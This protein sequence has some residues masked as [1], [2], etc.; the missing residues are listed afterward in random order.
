MTTTRKEH[1]EDRL[2]GVERWLRSPFRLALLV[3]G[4]VAL[5]TAA[6]SLGEVELRRAWGGGPDESDLVVRQGV[7]WLTWAL[8]AAPLVGLAGVLARHTRP[9]PVTFLSH[10]P[11]AIVVG[12]GILVVENELTVWVQGPERTEHIRE[13]VQWLESSDNTE[14]RPPWERGGSSREE[15]AERMGQDSVS[16]EGSESSEGTESSEG[17]G[18]ASG[19]EPADRERRDRSDWR[20]RRSRANPAAYGFVTGDIAD[21]FGRRWTLRVPRYALTYFALIGIGL[22]IRSFLVGRAREREAHTL[23]VRAGHLESALTEAKLGALQGQ[24]MPHFLFNALHSIGGLIRTERPAEALTALSSIGDLLRTSLDAGGE[25]FV[26]LE[27]E[28][29][30]IERYLA[31]EKLRLGDR[32][33]IEIDAP[34]EL[35]AAEVPA[36]IAQPL[37][38][39][40]IKHAIADR[41]EGGS[42]TVRVRAEDGTRLVIDIEDDGPG[43][44]PGG[45][46]GVGLP[47]VR[48][49]LQALFDDDA[50]LEMTTL[51]GGGT[52]ARLV[53]PLDDLETSA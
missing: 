47:H 25:Q 30:L 43:F 48:S 17:S 2:A 53:L 16:S 7:L 4:A 31:V 1:G 12:S 45:H 6:T 23:A 46:E 28:L 42:L 18:G 44:Q 8:I 51:D 22:G 14:R 38:E 26:P 10:L 40:A 29:E 19:S 34:S 39:N 52:R 50:R 41:T 9:W 32:L 35:L 21:D 24:L 13:R 33:V 27:R 3:L 20:R 11:I 36:F 5:A 49:R 15:R 37:V